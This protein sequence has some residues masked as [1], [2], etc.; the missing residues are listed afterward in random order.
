[1]KTLLDDQLLSKF[2]AACLSEELAYSPPRLTVI[3]INYLR[4]GV[5]SPLLYSLI[6]FIKV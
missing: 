2:L 5:T 1:M 6:L 3:F 4:I